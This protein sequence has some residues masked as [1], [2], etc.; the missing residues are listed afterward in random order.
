MCIFGEQD[1][2]EK[3]NTACEYAIIVRNLYIL[4]WP[5]RFNDYTLSKYHKRSLLKFTILNREAIL[6]LI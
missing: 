6:L 1:D 5:I 3:K 4:V 2:E